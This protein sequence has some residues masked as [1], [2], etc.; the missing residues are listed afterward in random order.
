MGG[1]LIWQ[2]RRVQVCGRAAAACA[3]VPSPPGTVTLDPA[4]SPDG[5]TLALIQAPARASPGFPQPVVARWYGTHQLWLYHPATHSVRRLNARGAAV[6][7]WSADG[8]S[9]LYAARDG[10]WLLPSLTGRPVRIATPLFR[11]GHWPAY[12]GQV[13]WA[14]QFAWWSGQP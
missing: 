10:I 7:A 11:P 2:D 13:S 4:W 9:L 6:P 8:N 5:T 12:Y 3:A 14:A 1:R